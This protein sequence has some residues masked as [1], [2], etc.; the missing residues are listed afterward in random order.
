[1]IKY[2]CFYF[3]FD[4]NGNIPAYRR[5]LSFVC[6]LGAAVCGNILFADFI[7]F[8]FFSLSILRGY[9]QGFF[10]IFFWVQKIRCCEIRTNEASKK[11][12]ENQA[13]TSFLH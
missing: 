5:L 11:A 3:L 10:L 4:A 1:M 7:R 2:V 12:S 6:W 9:F 13:A 8:D